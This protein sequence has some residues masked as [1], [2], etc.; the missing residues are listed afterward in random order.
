MEMNY[1]ERSL[2]FN[3]TCAK[4]VTKALSASPGKLRRYVECDLRTTPVKEKEKKAK[5]CSFSR[6]VSKASCEEPP[7]I[8]N[9]PLLY[10]FTVKKFPG[11]D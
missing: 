2:P 6:R 11:Y 7:R 9:N 3:E 1:S 5:F 8:P 10:S 4:F